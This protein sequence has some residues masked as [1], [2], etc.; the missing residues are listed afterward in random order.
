[1]K[2]NIGCPFALVLLIA[3]CFLQVHSSNTTVEPYCSPSCASYVGA[4][5]GP[6]PN[7]CWACST[8]L[9]LLQRNSSGVCETKSQHQVVFYELKNS[10]M[11]LSGY[12]TSKPAPQICDQYT[13]SGQYVAG[14]FIQKTFTGIPANHYQ[15]VIRFGVGYI[16]TWNP[17]DQMN[18]EINGSPYS[19]LYHG[20]SYPQDLCSTS[21]ADCFKIVEQ[22]ITHDTTNLTLKFSS[23]I[24]EV[25]P[26]V[27]YWGIKD[28]TIGVRTCHARC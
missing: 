20:C 17:T 15:L 7:E 13:L 9:F 24:A 27:Q 2:H 16:G 8:S 19:W 1:M 18:L 25:N 3:V 28:L 5:F 21:T 11:D 26:S 10:A 4:C 12:S 22:V 6:G 14:D 23:S